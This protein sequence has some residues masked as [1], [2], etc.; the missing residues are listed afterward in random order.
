MSMPERLKDRVAVVTG[1]GH[2]IGRASALRLGLEGARVVASDIRADAARRV[3]AGHRSGNVSDMT[4]ELPWLE[5]RF[6][7]RTARY[8][9]RTTGQYVSEEFAHEHPD[10]TYRLRRRRALPLIVAVAAGVVGLAA[11]AAA[12][13]RSRR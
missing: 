8:R 4:R 7:P 11:L 13:Y 9:S 5:R 12:T 10:D 3:C 1:A 2:R 6:G